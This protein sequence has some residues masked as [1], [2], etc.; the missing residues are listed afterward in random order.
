MDNSK[1]SFANGGANLIIQSLDTNDVGIYE[2]VARSS[3]G[4][5]RASAN[6]RIRDQYG[7]SRLIQVTE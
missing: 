4:E 1:Y 7:K 2:C 6:F 3:V 5:A